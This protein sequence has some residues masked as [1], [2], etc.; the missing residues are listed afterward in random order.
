MKIGTLCP[1]IKKNSNETA[2]AELEEDVLSINCRKCSK[3]PDFRSPECM[4][5]IMHHISQQGNAG[6]IRLR[7][8]K[9][10]ELF[11]PAAE[12]LCEM[13][14]LYRPAAYGGSQGG[15]RACS[16]CSSSCS[17]V[18][19][20]VWSG[21]PDP[22]FDSARGRLASFRPTES[23]CN[24]C[25]QRTYRALD[26]AELGMNNLRKKISIETARTGGV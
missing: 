26:Q 9:D 18:M 6:R 14:A 2:D 22:N 11:G 17:K 13:A 19:E 15:S 12:T 20:I 7:T 3:V 25:L 1:T 23:G 16:D 10:L 8:S 5:C 21:F 4:K 24:T